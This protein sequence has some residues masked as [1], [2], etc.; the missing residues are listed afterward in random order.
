MYDILLYP[1]EEKIVYLI[2]LVLVLYRCVDS[3]SISKGEREHNE[4]ARQKR[5]PVAG[6]DLLI[7]LT[8]VIHVRVS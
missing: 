8:D 7:R 4:R 2:I 1:K 3:N 5:I 6:V